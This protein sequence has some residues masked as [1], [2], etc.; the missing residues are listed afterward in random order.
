MCTNMPLDCKLASLNLLGTGLTLEGAPVLL[1]QLC[2]FSALLHLDITNNPGLRLLPVGMLNF[3]KLL[4][5]FACD[6]FS[7]KLFSTPDRNPSQ[8]RNLLHQTT[9]C[10]E[11]AWEVN[12][13]AA[14]LTP[15]VLPEAAN[16]LGLF[17]SL[18]CLDLSANVKLGSGGACDILSTLKGTRLHSYLFFFLINKTLAGNQASALMQL[19][20]S[21]MSLQVAG[22]SQLAEQLKRFPKLKV[23]DLSG[24]PGLDRASISEFLDSLQCKLACFLFFAFFVIFIV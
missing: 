6:G 16:V 17:P 8:I 20:L 22:V 3:A 13:A 2:K 11:T 19:S 24:N 14:E 21:R 23:L 1:E 4:D 9:E 5:T 12:L 10:V 7:Q 18:A 15:A